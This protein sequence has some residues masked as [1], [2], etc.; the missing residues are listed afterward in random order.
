LKLQ[1]VSTLLLP[2]RILDNDRKKK[3]AKMLKSRL[4]AQMLLLRTP[5]HKAMRCAAA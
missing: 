2:Q 4:V 5:M 1:S 3:H